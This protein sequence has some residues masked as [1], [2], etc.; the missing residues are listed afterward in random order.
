[1]RNANVVVAD[2][3][4][5]EVKRSKAMVSSSSVPIDSTHKQ[6]KQELVIADGGGAVITHVAVAS[7]VLVLALG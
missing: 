6:H 4:E 1:M 2:K 3:S 7:L 5:V